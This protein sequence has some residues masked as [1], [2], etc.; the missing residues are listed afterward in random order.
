M[1]KLRSETRI[2]KGELT[3]WIQKPKT[4]FAILVRLLLLQSV[5]IALEQ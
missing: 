2:P 1:K 3:G 4:D 5:P